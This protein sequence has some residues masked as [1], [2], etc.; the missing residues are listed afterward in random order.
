MELV[1]ST[2]QKLD[3]VLDRVTALRS[4]D[5]PHKHSKEAL[6]AIENIFRDHQKTI[7]TLGVGSDQATVYN[8]CNVVLSSLSDYLPLLGFLHRSKNASNAFELYGPLLRLAQQLIGQNAKFIFSSEWEFSPYT[9]V[10][11][12]RLPGFVWLGLPASESSNAL[13]TPLSGHEFGHSVWELENLGNKYQVRIDAAIVEAIIKDWPAYHALFP[14]VPDQ[15]ALI[16]DLFGTRSWRP[17]HE[18]ALSQ[19]EE[20]FCDLL[21]LRIFGSAYLHA[22]AYLLAPGDS[23]RNTPRYPTLPERVRLMTTAAPHYGILVP[24]GY[25]ALFQGVTQPPSASSKNAY[26][27][28]LADGAVGAISEELTAMADN[29]AGARM[30]PP[31]DNAEVHSIGESFKQLVPHGKATSIATII[32]AA[33]VIEHTPDIWIE[34]EKVVPRRRMVL[35][36][37]VLKTVQ[38]LDFN[39]LLA[40]TP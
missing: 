24:A 5:F 15:N 29:I 37:L 23:L 32:N 25:P 4:G 27:L 7:N 19:A 3:A 2:N 12:P 6:E 17:A 26:L 38:V 30:I 22:F 36:E 28:S 8:H 20:I 35:N 21:G 39:A 14:E 11:I 34:Y 33:W 40:A 31:I 9:I 1:D 18:W 10:G 13:L 16:N